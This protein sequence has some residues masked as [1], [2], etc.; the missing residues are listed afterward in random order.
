MMDAVGEA[1]EL[2]S[3]GLMTVREAADFLAVGHSL[4][5][6]LMEEGWLAYVKLGR[7]RRI[8][9]RAAIA[10]AQAN[11]RGGWNQLSAHNNRL[12]DESETA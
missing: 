11:V 1:N 3:D 12:R 10:L 8:P 7:A 9:K 4:L 2:M 6:K 5:Y